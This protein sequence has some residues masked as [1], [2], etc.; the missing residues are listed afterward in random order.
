MSRLFLTRSVAPEHREEKGR[1]ARNQ[2]F[3]GIARGFAGAI[4]FSLPL[5]MTMEM[6]QLGFYMDRIRM[7]V[8]LIVM[9][10]MLVAISYYSGFRESRSWADNMADALVAYG[11]ALTASAI[12]LLLFNVIH[13][14]MPADE[15]IG[16]IALQSIPGAFGA[17]LASSQLGK[18]GGDPDEEERKE[19]GG[20]GTEIVLMAGG[21]MFLAFNVAP[22]EEMILL[23]YKMTAWHGLILMVFTLGLLHAFV[24]AVNFRGEHDIPEGTPWWSLFFRYSVVGYAISLA[25]SGYVLWTFGRLDDFAITTYAMRTIVLGFPAG[26]G[27]AAARLIL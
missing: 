20:Y 16:K 1:E 10:P 3:R 6:W 14:D 13:F 22:T 9:F 15:V 17:V 18:E 24:Y 2:F 4:L 23:A 8:F 11:I 21:A 25:V 5:L 7:A 26:L 19:S 27:A 12:V